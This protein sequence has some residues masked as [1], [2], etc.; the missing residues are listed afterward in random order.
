MMFWM[1]PCDGKP[2]RL[3]HQTIKAK[4]RDSAV[5]LLDAVKNAVLQYRRQIHKKDKGALHA[6]DIKVQQITKIILE[7]N[8]KR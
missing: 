1:Q 2:Y 4:N 6:P 7:R 8:H 3:K 5:W